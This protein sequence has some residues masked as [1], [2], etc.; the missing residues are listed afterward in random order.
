MDTF[1]TELFKVVKKLKSNPLRFK[2]KDLQNTP[3][4]R[5]FYESELQKVTKP[6]SIGIE[7]ILGQKKIND[8]VYYEIKWQHHPEKFNSFIP[9]SSIEKIND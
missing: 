9:A 6:H 1:S 4:A 3:I 5:S 8:E 7:K 2:L